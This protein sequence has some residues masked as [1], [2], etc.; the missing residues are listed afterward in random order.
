MSVPKLVSKF[1]W[2]YQ[3][4]IEVKQVVAE[5][6]KLDVHDKI[7][8]WRDPY[9]PADLMKGYITRWVEEDSSGDREYVSDIQFAQSD[10]A[11]ERLVVCKEL[12]HI[13]DPENSRVRSE[14]ELSHLIGR[15]ILPPHLQDI[16]ANETSHV[17]TDRVAEIKAVAVLFPWNARMALV[18][19][20]KSGKVTLEQIAQ[21]AKLPLVHTALVMNDVWL[22]I[23]KSLLP[24]RSS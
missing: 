17:V 8:Y 13:L 4:P 18:P 7:V 1:T 6:R 12:L 5:L 21:R 24:G 10:E 11:T 14:E 22:Q 16:F 3:L 23:H 9:L 2:S 19:N 15:I 20:Y